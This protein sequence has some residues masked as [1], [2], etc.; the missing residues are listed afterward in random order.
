MNSK[1]QKVILH[2]FIS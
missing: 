2:K 1:E